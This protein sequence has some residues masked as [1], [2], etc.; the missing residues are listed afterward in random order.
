MQ[1]EREAPQRER[2]APTRERESL[3]R[4][5]EAP[6]RE[7]EPLR[8]ERASS[9]HP[10]A[11]RAILASAMGAL[12]LACLVGCAGGGA[13]TKS[14][15]PAVSASPGTTAR[16]AGEPTLA[17]PGA[18]R[19]LGAVER[20]DLRAFDLASAFPKRNL[21]RRMS[22]L[23]ACDVSLNT[24]NA[25]AKR[26]V[27]ALLD[28]YREADDPARFAELVL[29]RFEATRTSPAQPTE[30]DGLMTGYATPIVNVR[31][32][33]DD[34]PDARFR[35]PIFADL[36]GF[37]DA[38]AV[39]PRREILASPKARERAIAWIDDPMAWALVETNG[40]A[41]LR[42]D[43]TRKDIPISRVATNGRA[44]RSVGKGLAER[45]LVDPKTATLV[46]VA[47]AADANPREAEAAALENERVV[48]FRICD[49]AD[50]PPVLGIPKG[51]LVSGYSCA[52]DQSVYPPGSVLLVTERDAKG[53]ARPVR[54][55]FVHD[56]GGAI[57]GPQR[58]DAYFGSGNAAIREAGAMRFEVDVIR[59]RA[60]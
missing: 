25:D 59:L 48:F 2:E 14:G 29:E 24:E 42:I 57:S 21:D 10:R 46:D 35:F 43:G 7:R 4:E 37:D 5:R 6:Q 41:I 32:S 28:A 40:T 3:Q 18:P 13:A 56:A 20:V 17:P 12:A 58:V 49:P 9:R 33:P 38:L 1:R 15:D 47:R 23:A 36:R 60:R 53:A 51:E 45:G 19:A 39:A 22:F 31:L 52:A 8:R 50:F 26:D 30:L 11:M 55:L 54:I 16:I 27:R 44:F 34:G